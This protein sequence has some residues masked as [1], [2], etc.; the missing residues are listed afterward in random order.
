M[1]TLIPAKKED[2]EALYQWFMV[3]RLVGSFVM[4]GGIW[5]LWKFGALDFDPRPILF[6][7][8]PAYVVLNI[9]WIS[10]LKKNFHPDVF[11]YVQLFFDVLVI[12][13]GV[14]FSGGSHSQFVFLYVA[15][16]ISAS[17][18]SLAATVLVSLEAFLLFEL[19]ILGEYTK[20]L[21]PVT[22]SPLGLQ[23]NEII[24][25]IVLF[26]IA[27]IV[28]FQSYY[29]FKE[30][31]EQEGEVAKIK[32]EFLLRTVHDLRAPSNAIS[33][34]LEKFDLPEY[35]ARYPGLEKELFTIQD[36]NTRMLALLKDLG[37]VVKGGKSAVV[38]KREPVDLG[39]IIEEVSREF[40]QVMAAKSIHFASGLPESLPRV[41]GDSQAL[42]EVFSNLI[43]NAI[44][45]NR[46]GGSVIVEHQVNEQ[47]IKIAV[48]DTG[49]GI[50]QEN[51][52]KLFTLYFRGD[53]DKQIPGTG[54]GLY[55]V[56]RLVEKMDGK[57]EVVSKLGEGTTFT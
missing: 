36:L 11:L 15:P 12:T 51:L 17:I 42:K 3:V 22:S 27:V 16:I 23:G 54:L 19:I 21:A 18:V 38:L 25:F 39:K 2:Y 7:L 34:T 10:V 44:K 6:A 37:E 40:E 9:F 52:P 55:L 31:R 43:D 28:A 35:R 24:R 26:L 33:W 47:D 32:D 1:S 49:H 57:V 41:I 14:Y 8:I 20:I 30:A 56:K 45:Y 4:E 53:V 50:S 29:Y 46:D 13:I 5:T 48:Q